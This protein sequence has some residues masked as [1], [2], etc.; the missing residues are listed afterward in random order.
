[1]ARSSKVDSQEFKHLN[2]LL[3][4]NDNMNNIHVVYNRDIPVMDNA[5]LICGFPG[6]G[7]VGKL[8]VEHL[9]NE[10]KAEPLVDI[11]SSALP[12]QVVIRNDG[13]VELMKNTIYYYKDS[14]PLLLLTADSQPILPDAEYL[15][16]DTIFE[17]VKKIDTVFTLA[18]YITG[19]F[20]N[21]PKVY[22][23][24]TSKEL[25]EEIKKIGIETM[26]SGTVTGMNGVILG[27]ARLKKIKGICLLGET[28]GYVVDAN[29]SQAVLKVLGNILG[30]EIDMQ[31]L[32]RR[33][34]DAEPIIRAIE[35]QMQQAELQTKSSKDI[36]YIS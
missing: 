17:V 2:L 11:Y 7:Y 1:M 20:V 30:M 13:T 31:D 15:L 23:T 26:D 10:L 36:G 21:K 5:C 8:A 24:T 34:K 12:P 4:K 33:V 3:Y 28:S 27:L 32:E 25:L 29:A 18:A 14:R 6:S 22:A 16:A 35:Q 19:V 9:I